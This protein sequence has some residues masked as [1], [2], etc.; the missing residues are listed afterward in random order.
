MKKSL[1]IL[2]ALTL[3]TALAAPAVAQSAG[4]WTLGFGLGSVMPKSDNGSLAGG[5]LDVD[6]GDNIRPTLTAEYFI[7][8]NLGIEVLAAWPFTHSVNIDGLG[9]VAEATHLPPTLSLNY[10]FNTGGAFAPFI[11]A[12]VNFTTFLDVDTEGALA[13]DDLDLDESWGLA[14]HLGFDY[15]VSER[16]ALRADI[17]YIDINSDV[18]L[19]GAKIGEVEIDPWVVGISY[20]MKF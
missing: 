15:W 5:T 20:I 2:S 18:K 12:G 8:D 11:G 3:S 6:V 1:A 7:R 14:A 17:R 19:N 9:K 13:A 10:H 16:G 4:E